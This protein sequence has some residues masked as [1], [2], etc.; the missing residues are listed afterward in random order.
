MKAVYDKYYQDENL[1]GEPYKELV[2]FFGQYEPKKTVLDIG[3][4]QGRDAIALAKIGYKVHGID[5]SKV[6]LNQLD[7]YSKRHNLSITTEY[8]DIFDSELNLDFD[9]IL[10]DSMFHF[11]KKDLEE[12]KGLLVKILKQSKQNT[13]I[14][15]FIQKGKHREEVL[16]T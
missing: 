13:V 8:K 14:A 7:T 5:I 2:D 9:I 6:G 3:C 16:I 11:Y 1:F 15:L 12:E 10:L 4:G